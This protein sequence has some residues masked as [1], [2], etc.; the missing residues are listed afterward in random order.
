MLER[1]DK[2]A[3]NDPQVAQKVQEQVNILGK[4]KD[5]P[6]ETDQ[7]EPAA[8]PSASYRE[9][10]GN[11]TDTSASVPSSSAGSSSRSTPETAR[12]TPARETASVPT[13]SAGS[14]SRS[15]PETARTTPAL[16]TPDAKDTNQERANKT[17]QTNVTAND[18]NVEDPEDIVI[19]QQIINKPEDGVPEGFLRGGWGHKYAVVRH[20]PPGAARY[21]LVKG[22]KAKKYIDD[23]PQDLREH[24]V[25][26]VKAKKMEIRALQG[27]V[28]NGDM[29]DF[30]L[31]KPPKE[32]YKR[33]PLL[34]IK[35]KWGNSDGEIHKSW[36]TRATVRESF[37]QSATIDDIEY[38]YQGKVILEQG[39]QL[40]VPDKAIILCAIRCAERYDAYK[41]N[42]SD[43]AG[44]EE[45][46]PSP[47]PHIALGQEESLFVT[48]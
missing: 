40:S 15:T 38:K 41:K 45:H 46:S 17:P 7:P 2:A 27:V 37:P 16:E 5:E 25:D 30:E 18:P 28:C 1:L 31:L 10:S 6:M 33:G 3:Q 9:Q 4:V 14:S 43:L 19:P 26:K 32:A 36:E 13:S 34:N 44:K 48:A 39:S 47:D 11:G 24:R 12:T 22:K 29:N 35:V 42:P 23:N 8:D 20:G 21:E